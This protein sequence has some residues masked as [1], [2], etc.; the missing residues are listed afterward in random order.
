MH[1]G[2]RNEGHGHR[3]GTTQGGQGVLTVLADI[4]GNTVLLNILTQKTI[5]ADSDALRTRGVDGRTLLNLHRGVHI[6]VGMLG[7]A[8]LNARGGKVA[9]VVRRNRG[10]GRTGAGS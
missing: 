10:L 9:G 3:T 1:V 8:L 6:A 7:A 2:S 4:Y 5:A